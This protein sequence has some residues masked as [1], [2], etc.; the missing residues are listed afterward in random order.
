LGRPIGLVLS[1]K[2]AVARV[3]VGSPQGIHSPDPGR[4]RRGRG[5]LAGYTWLHTTLGAGGLSPEDLGELGRRRWDLVAALEVG[6]DGLPGL[7]HAAHLLPSPEAG[8]DERLLEPFPPGQPPEDLARLVRALEEELGRR[9]GAQRVGRSGAAL[10]VSVSSGPEDEAAERL[11]ELAELARSAGL[12]VVGR[13]VQRRR[14]PDPRTIIGPGKLNQVLLSAMRSGADVLVL[15]QELTPGQARSLAAATTADIKFIDRTQLILDIFAQRAATREGKLQVEMAQ[16]RYLLPRLGYRDGGLS[17][18]TGGI[19]GRGPGETKLEIDRRRVRQRLTRLERE[20]EQIARQ[21]GRRRSARARGGLPVLSLVGY[22]NAG[23][24]TLLN[25]LT[26]S[27]V[28]T[29]DRLFATLDPTTRRLRFPREREV[30]ITDTVGFIR[31]LPDELKRAFAAT[32]EELE[33]A[34]VL[35]HVADAANPRVEEQIQAV[36]AILDEMAFSRAPR[37]LVINKADIAPAE[38]LERLGNRYG[39][40]AVSARIPSTLTPLLERMEEM[41]AGAGGWSRPK[42]TPSA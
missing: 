2:G 22:T 10:L 5:R 31:D 8:V 11:D 24:S 4:L 27:K 18:L 36:E 7:I 28:K 13:V 19:G 37:L 17:R 6:P 42:G 12:S 3:V 41:V 32:L 34:Q 9:A 15:D 23:K 1:R 30:I 35:L 40:V 33:Q 14:K 21:R 25:A 29:E 38:A 20:L 39:G 16:L 26:G